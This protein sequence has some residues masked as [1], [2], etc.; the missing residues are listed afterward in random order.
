M[1]KERSIVVCAPNQNI[2]WARNGYERAV[3]LLLAQLLNRRRGEQPMDIH[4]WN[5]VGVIVENEYQEY[6]ATNGSI[7]R[8]EYY[9]IQLCEKYNFLSNLMDISNIAIENDHSDEFSDWIIPKLVKL[10]E[11]G[12]LYT[13]TARF[14]ICANCGNLIAEESVAVTTC[15]ICK[16]NEILQDSRKGIFIDFPNDKTALVRG[17][18]LNLKNQKQVQGWFANL[19]P[20]A[21]LNKTRKS[22]INLSYLGFPEYVLDPGF[23][24]SLLPEFIAEKYDYQ[25]VTQIQGVKTAT[26]TIPFTSLTNIDKQFINSYFL[27]HK[28]PSGSLEKAQTQTEKDFYW[29]Y[30]L[31]YLLNKESD[32]TPQETQGLFEEYRKL[33]YKVNTV[34]ETVASNDL[35]SSRYFLSDRDREMANMITSMILNMEVGVALKSAKD[36]L[37][38][39]LREYSPRSKQGE[40]MDFF[41]YSMIKKIFTFLM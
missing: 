11:R 10:T 1:S 8:D 12:V 5:D 35:L 38:T 23:S 26:N 9:Q 17:N 29:K 22:G 7:S 16:S 14:H 28:I 40:K 30:L 32:L 24:I 21:F 18:V 37:K 13:E 27:I 6:I 20:R 39:I 36:F 2:D 41:D 3:P 25:E 33:K 15:K 19:P 4:L 34:I 31:L